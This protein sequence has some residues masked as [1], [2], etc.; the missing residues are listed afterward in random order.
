MIQTAKKNFYNFTGGDVEK[1]NL[2]HKTQFMVANPP[3]ERFKE[4]LSGSSLNNFLVELKDVS[5][6]YSIFSANS[7]RLNEASTRNKPKKV[8]EE[9]MK[10]PKEFYRLHKF[11]TL[12]A[13]VVF[14]NGI[15]FLVTFSRNIILIT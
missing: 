15:P 3:D 1:E 13:D 9:Y 7:N 10:I 6:S 14:V 5:N 2:S 12:T 4:I 8:K 11:F